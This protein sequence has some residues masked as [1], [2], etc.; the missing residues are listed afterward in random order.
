MHGPRFDE[1]LR[2][3]PLTESVDLLLPDLAGV[4][5]RQAPP[6]P[7][8]VRRAIDGEAFFTT[9]VYAIDTPG[10]NVDGER[11]GL[12]GGRRRPASGASTRRPSAPGAVA[13]RRRPDARRHGRAGRQRLLRRLPPAR[14][15]G[16]RRGSPPSGLR[17]VAALEFEFY[18]IDATS[19]EHGAPLVPR[20]DR[21]GRRPSET[22]VFA[23]ERMEDQ[24]AFFELVERYCEAQEL[25][26]KGALVRVRARASSRSISAMSTTWC[27]PPTRACCSSAA[28]RRRRAPPASAPPSWP[29]PSP[30]RAAAACTSI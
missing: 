11:A 17:P 16:W 4:A 23:P 18:L 9:T 29:S 20:S 25:P 5:A 3:H 6:A 7:S 30:S 10:A 26:I 1:F 12:G 22:E 24:E 2:E 19:G 14:A 27:W 8:A 13:A 15:H 28:S 21:L